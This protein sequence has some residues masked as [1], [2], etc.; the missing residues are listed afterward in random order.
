MRSFL[1]ADNIEWRAVNLDQGET[2]PPLQDY[3]ALWVMGGPMDVWDV[4]QHPWLI[5]EKEAIPESVYRTSSAFFAP[6]VR[7]A[8]NA[9]V[10]GI[11]PHMEILLP[12]TVL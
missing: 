11:M 8:T 3:D 1:A 4:E 12:T 7:A 6:N 9:T 2:I 10:V 5:A